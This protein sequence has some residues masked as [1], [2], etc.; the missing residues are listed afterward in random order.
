MRKLQLALVRAAGFGVALVGAA[1]TVPAN[2]APVAPNGFFSFSFPGP[3]SV[4]TGNITLQTASVSLGLGPSGGAPI[5]SFG[6]PFV[7]NP[8]NFCGAAG[9][10]CTDAHPPGFLFPNLSIVTLSNVNL[11]VS[12]AIS[13]TPIAETAVARTD[14]G[15]LG[16]VLEVDFDFTSIFTQVRSDNSFVL[17]LLGTVDGSF[18]NDYTSGQDAHMAIICTQSGLGPIDCTGDISTFSAVLGGPA[19]VPEPTSLAVLGSTLFGFNIFRRRL[20]KAGRGSGPSRRRSQ[21]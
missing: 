6:D 10:G 14:F 12:S 13:P 8:N 9:A 4:D 16:G 17:S 3:N 7:G 20:A 21:Q 11:P 19:A 1:I 15:Q 5:T 18:Q 2:A